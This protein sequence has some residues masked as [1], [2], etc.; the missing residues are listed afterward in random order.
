VARQEERT[1]V[2][3]DSKNDGTH[4]SDIRQTAGMSM[5]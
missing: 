3:D 1:D 4:H 5:V 2:G